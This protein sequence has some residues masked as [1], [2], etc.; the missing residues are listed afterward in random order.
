MYESEA[1][2][3]A[4]SSQVIWWFEV[5]NQTLIAFHNH[6]LVLREEHLNLAF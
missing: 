3:Y 2:I 1:G 6:Y 5:S 4:M